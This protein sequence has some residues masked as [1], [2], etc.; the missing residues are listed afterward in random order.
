[1]ALA[2]LS[3]HKSRSALTILGI[4][5]G[6]TS[7]IIVMSLGQSATNLIIGEVQGLGANNIVIL[8]GR[9]P[10]GPT[11]AGGSIINDSLK[12][13]DLD[14][15]RK[16][17]N[18]PDSIGAIP[19]V[20]GPVNASYGSEVFS[21]MVIGTDSGIF[22]LY[23]LDVKSGTFFSNEDT[24]A[25]AE[26]V[27]IG[28]K[29]AD[30]LFGLSDPVGEKIKIKEKNYR[31]VGIL[32]AKGQ[33][34]FVNFDES[35]LTPYTTAQQYMLG[36]RYLQRIVVEAQSKSTIDNVVADVKILLRNN[37]NIDD[38]SKDDFY[39][40]TQADLVNTVSTV[41]SV[42]TI[43]LSSV[44]AISLIVGGVGIMNI[45]FVSVT[46]RTREIGLRKALGATNSNIMTQFLTEA[47]L[48]TASGGLAGIILGSLFSYL[49]TYVIT[50][51]LGVN[52]P[53][54]FS[55]TGLILG[56]SVSTSIGLIFG[57]FPARSA[58]RKSPIEA[59]RYE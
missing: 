32:E 5:I 31:V 10:R 43:L 14:D 45:M 13:K 39:I 35:I 7:I 9:Q 44:A 54:A 33:S 3:T 26:V 56:V 23:R 18:V 4:V 34:P 27:I 52:F 17:S 55:F 21:T 47:V 57:L 53:F 24:A 59:L 19:I 58:A 42:L 30:E 36:I 8:P 25:R 2:G 20:F 15:L 41:T 50:R 51:F 28:Q 22:D 11:D 29:V 1:M 16:S 12:L 40:Q 49:V 46:E 48:L 37:H 38:P 6:I